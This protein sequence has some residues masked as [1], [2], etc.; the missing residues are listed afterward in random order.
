METPL[1]SVLNCLECGAPI[2]AEAKGLCPRCLLKLGLASQLS[3]GFIETG[4][5]PPPFLGF[6]PVDPSKRTVIEPFEFGGYRILRLLGKGGMGAVYE[7][8]E[9]A[10]GRRVALKVLGHSLDSADTRKR[11]IREGRLAASI[12]HPNSVYV[13]GTEEIEGAPVITMEL[14][15]GGTLHE[16][17]KEGG[18][19]PV[20][21]AVDAILQIIAGLEA[22]HAVGILH[23]DIKPSNCFI[24]PSGTVKIGDFGLSISTLSRGDSALTLAGS[25]LGTPEFSSPEQLRG[26]ELNVRSDIYSVGMTLYYLLTGKTAFRAENV[27]QLLATVLDKAPQPPREMRAE[28]PESLSRIV[29]RCLAKQA[30]ERPASYDELRRALLPFTSTAPTP[31]TLGLRFVA[32]VIDVLLLTFVSTF[33]PMLLFRDYA[34]MVYGENTDLLPYLWF[35]AT[36][37]V[38]QL[39]YFAVSE[40]RWGATPGKALVGLRVGGLDR[41]APGIPRALLRAFIYLVPAIIASVVYRNG[42]IA[43]ES[44]I[45]NIGAAIAL[46]LYPVLLAATARRRN[47]FATVIDLLTK[48][49]VIQKSAYEPRE[50]VAQTA[51]PVAT[52]EAMPQIGPYHALAALGSDG[53]GELILGYDTKLLRRVWIRKTIADPLDSTQG[54]RA[55]PVPAALRNSAR[56]GRLRWLQGRRDA[57]ESW[58]AYEAAPGTPLTALLHT[59]QPWKNVRHW[60]LDLAEEFAAA[61]R[62]GSLPPTLSLDRVWITASGGAKLLD[63]RAPGSSCDASSQEVAATSP[64]PADGTRRGAGS[65]VGHPPLF[66]SATSAGT[67]CDGGVA[68]AKPTLFLNQLAISTLEGR[69]A[70]AEEARARTPHVPVPIRARGVLG[71]LRAPGDFA[72]LAG[73]LKALVRQVPHITRRRRLGLV[74]GCVAPALMLG[75]FMFAGVKMIETWKR[76]Y[77]EAMQLGDALGAFNTMSYRNLPTS[78]DPKERVEAAEIFIAGSYGNFIRDPKAWNSRVVSTTILPKMRAHAERIAATYPNPSAAEMERARAVLAPLLDAQGHF[79]ISPDKDDLPAFKTQVVWWLTGGTML[80]AAFFSLV[81][82]VLFR[83]GLLMRALGIAVVRSDGSDASRGRMLWRACLAWAWLPPAFALTFYLN[84]LGYKETSA[85]IVALP[86][87]CLAIWSAASPGRSLPDRLA[88][89]WLVP[90]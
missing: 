28:I 46:Y 14:V 18:A 8:E 86:V 7:A 6:D 72:V 1:N 9:L 73:Q 20:A 24:E 77:P 76:Q 41:N 42:P 85:A 38:F 40:G 17:V 81:A 33:L 34:A 69:V 4:A 43:R 44:L 89:T 12:N 51:E 10:S 52:T 87:L 50:S 37:C 63:F 71:V 61:T 26:E 31:A 47:G 57:A 78:R 90:R 19:M 16:R 68:T 59:P 32:G 58:D 2:S 53:D 66:P 45:V 23:R 55:A 84:D 80:W 30:A 35:C 67:S 36:V 11:F 60:L 83:G 15:P 5:E 48:T 39:A 74:A 79:S 82:A 62:D 22:A 29:L 49:R 27:V 88:G 3:P 13:Y 64:S 21:E 54:T 75:G 65:P 25:I 70:S 56:P